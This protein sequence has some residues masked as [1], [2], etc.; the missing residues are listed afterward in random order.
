M[1]I[2]GTN[3]R[4]DMV[5][6]NPTSAGGFTLSLIAKNGTGWAAPAQ[7]IADAKAKAEHALGPLIWR[8]QNDSPK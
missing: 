2:T 7:S 5:K 6:I 3:K 1:T 8:E 4:G